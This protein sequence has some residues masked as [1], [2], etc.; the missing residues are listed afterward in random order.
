MVPQFDFSV[1]THRRTILDP[2]KLEYMNKHHLMQ[3]MSTPE[4]L[5]T[6]AERTLP[7]VKE[8][9]PDR[10]IGALFLNPCTSY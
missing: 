10:Y 9:F 1:I 8:H 5:R 4:G 6:L 2:T 7:F 3:V